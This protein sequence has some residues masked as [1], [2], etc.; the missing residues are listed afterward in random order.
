MNFVLRDRNCDSERSSVALGG[1]GLAQGVGLAGLE[2]L[3][4]V[5][6]LV[7][8]LLRLNRVGDALRAR[9]DE[10]ARLVFKTCGEYV[11]R[12][13][14][15]CFVVRPRVHNDTR[16]RRYV[17]DDVAIFARAGHVVKRPKIPE[18]LIDAQPF[19]FV[20]FVPAERSRFY[21]VGDKPLDEIE[22]QKTSSAC[23]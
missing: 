9:I 18:P 14:N 2:A 21:P 4:H 16:K 6:R 15:V 1:H 3:D 7:D 23:Y 10:F 12:A 13:E 11:F 20:V 22:T 5:D 8:A 17:V 19:E